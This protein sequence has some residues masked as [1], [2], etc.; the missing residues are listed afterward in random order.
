MSLVL[1]AAVRAALSADLDAPAAL[2]AVDVWSD[3][4]L[5]ADGT[6]STVIGAP[7]VVSR[8]VNA[9]LGVRL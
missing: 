7:G 4:A 5:R 6:D 1:L 8:A 3:D 2:A 9:L